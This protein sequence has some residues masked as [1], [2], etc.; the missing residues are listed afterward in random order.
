M[1][2]V[3][4]SNELAKLIYYT[5]NNFNKNKNEKNSLFIAF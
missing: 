3:L 1:I 4:R 2:Y 5:K